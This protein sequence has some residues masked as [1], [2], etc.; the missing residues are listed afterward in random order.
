MKARRARVNVALPWVA[1]AWLGLLAGCAGSRPIDSSNARAFPALE[2]ARVL[3]IQVRREPA[4]IA[5]TNTTASPIPPCTMWINQRYSRPFEGLGVGESVSLPL[6][7]FVD[8]FGQRFR[9]G[10]FWA[11]RASERVVLAQF[12]MPGADQQPVLVGTVVVNGEEDPDA[13]R[14]RANPYGP[15]R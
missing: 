7:S 15:S 1:I 2:Q 8:E 5:L 3:D 13:R 11:T 9:P 6:G 12:E 10:G 4:T 14:R